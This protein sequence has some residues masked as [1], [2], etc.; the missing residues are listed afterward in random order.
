MGRTVP[1]G[2]RWGTL[3]PPP[4]SFRYDEEAE[5]VRRGIGV[6]MVATAMLLAGCGLADD[7]KDAAADKARDVPGVSA[8]ADCAA[9]ARAVTSANVDDPSATAE[10]LEEQARQ[11]DDRIRSIESTE[12]R[13]A[14]ETLSQ[15]VKSLA[16][17]VARND[18]ADRQKALD[19][20]RTAARDA[21]GACGIPVEQILGG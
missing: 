19:D 3:A 5:L 11:L 9:L 21:A 10:S 2:F 15:R 4:A 14:V 1:T 8:V 12:V 16:E 18:A 7:A 17:A 6:A 20:V 13:Q